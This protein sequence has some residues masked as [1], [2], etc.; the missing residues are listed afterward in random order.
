[1]DFL[2]VKT[3][4][5]A[6]KIFGFPEPI[7]PLITII[8]KWPKFDDFIKSVKISGDMYYL[9][10]KG[11]TV[12]N[13]IQYGRSSYDFEE[14]SLI[15]LAPNQTI[16]V[17]DSTDEDYISWTI[18]FHPDL[19]RKTPLGKTIKNFSFFNYEANEALHLSEKEKLSLIELIEK[20][21]SEMHQT[22]DK[23]SDE[24]IVQ[25]LETILKYSSRYYDRQ[26]F[27]R[28]NINKD[29]V[30][31]FENYLIEY[32]KSETLVEK[33][34]PT[35]D[36]CGEALS[37]SGSY[38]SDLLKVETGRSAKDHIHSYII[39]EAKTKLLNS[40]IPVGQVAY[41]L[42]FEYPQHFSKLFKSKVGMSPS[43]YRK[44][45]V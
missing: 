2:H 45:I 36:M 4:T 3:V 28:S 15:F 18:V 12:D 23:Y 6:H 43:E 17:V 30:S 37:I 14:G 31:K 39:E 32:F 24:L 35:L 40:N 41:K 11:K 26:F 9:A 27:T 13:T 10:M 19:I 34:L 38:L 33:G 1:M 7:H 20:I 25:N 16:S 21:D 8:R 29:V 5:E 42:G 44:S 22:R